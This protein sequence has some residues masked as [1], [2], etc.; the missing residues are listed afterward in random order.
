[1][2]LRLT[3]F[4]VANHQERK[5]HRDGLGILHETQKQKGEQLNDGEEQDSLQRHNT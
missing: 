1:L 5:K 4:K 2:L 3:G